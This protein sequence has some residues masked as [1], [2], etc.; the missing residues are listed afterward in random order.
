MKN[1]YLTIFAI[2]LVNFM[3]CDGPS[4]D[5]KKVA[6][7]S[8]ASALPNTVQTTVNPNDFNAYWFAGKAELA[9]YDL[10]IDRYD[11]PRKGYAAFVFVTEDLS[12]TRHVK[13]DNPDKAG[14]DRVP[15]LKLNAITRF[16]TGIYDY[17]LMSSLFTPIDVVKMPHSLKATTT[18]QD[19][20]GHV[21]T[22]MDYV[23]NNTYKV[24]QYSY[25]E[26]EGDK[27]FD[28]EE[29]VP[30]SRGVLL[31]DEI[32]TRLRINPASL[33]E[34]AMIIPNLTFTRLRHKPVTAS[35]ATI[36][37]KDME[38]G[39]RLCTVNYPD[40]KRRVEI[41][42]EAA[43]PHKIKSFAEFDGDKEMSR[44]TLIKSMMSDYWNKHDNQS[45][46]MREMLGL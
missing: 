27:V 3:A 40:L 43:F 46:Y 21:F 1:N 12:K 19:W 33:P 29:P 14:D 24:S 41:S 32:F 39:L 35:A 44:G 42:F 22:Q 15:V 45:D 2:L 30:P 36:S 8:S 16:Q 7:V 17:S 34:K 31:E 26:M 5:L 20:C 37:F 11:E 13:L 25:F 23:K 9:S 38:E 6:S 18:V 28:T 10:K 4:S